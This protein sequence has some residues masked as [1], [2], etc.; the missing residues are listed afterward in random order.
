[1]VAAASPV[2]LLVLKENGRQG[3]WGGLGEAS[4]SPVKRGRGLAVDRSQDKQRRKS[5]QCL[6]D[7]SGLAHQLPRAACSN[8]LTAH[9]LPLSL[10]RQIVPT[11]INPW[12][13]IFPDNM[14]KMDY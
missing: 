5:A 6:R 13:F 3:G 14:K 10:P 4:F 2:C 11:Q 7:A 1:M 12:T 8:Q 9:L